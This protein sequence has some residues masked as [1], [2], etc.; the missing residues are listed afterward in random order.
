MEETFLKQFLNPFDFLDGGLGIKQGSIRSY[1]SVDLWLLIAFIKCLIVLSFMSQ[2]NIDYSSSTY[3]TM[4]LRMDYFYYTSMLLASLNIRLLV[5]IFSLFMLVQDRSVMF[6]LLSQLIFENF[7]RF[8]FPWPL[9]R[10]ESRLLSIKTGKADEYYFS[11][12]FLEL[13][14]YFELALTKLL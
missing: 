3:S 5:S 4:E 8:F 1:G 10:Y 9:L 7:N 6:L 11:S 2:D 12:H 13:F 14:I